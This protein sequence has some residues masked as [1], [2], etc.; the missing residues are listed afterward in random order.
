M[1]FNLFFFLVFSLLLS[2][3]AYNETNSNDRSSEKI[4]TERA[5]CK[6]TIL[7]NKSN[8]TELHLK[9]CESIITDTRSS[10]ML[11]WYKKTEKVSTEIAKYRL[12]VQEEIGKLGAQLAI[13]EKH[14][15]GFYIE[16]RPD[17]SVN[18]LLKGQPNTSKII[19]LYKD[20]SWLHFVKIRQAKYSLKDLKAIRQETDKIFYGFKTHFL[21]S[22]HV[23]KN[24]IVYVIEDKKAFLFKLKKKNI[25]LHE[26]VRIREGQS[27]V[28]TLI[29][30]DNRITVNLPEILKPD[31]YLFRIQFDEKTV[32]TYKVH[33]TNKLTKDCKRSKSS[34]PI[35][36]TKNSRSH[37]GI[38][39]NSAVCRDKKNY[40]AKSVAPFKSFTVYHEPN[41]IENT[42][43][44]VKF[45]IE[46]LN[47]QGKA[48]LKRN[49]IVQFDP[50]SKRQ[51]NGE[52]CEPICYKGSVNL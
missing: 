39:V 1:H 44:Q 20:K 15:A 33:I 2:A 43:D 51:P 32:N 12:G 9:H 48:V 14:D 37:R 10:G 19:Q 11:D 52:R 36:A 8:V 17:F 49:K 50:K 6:N 26:S 23:Q 35:R 7:K 16:H 34:P 31:N 13:D 24:Q 28:C 3:C 42:N 21:S 29:G 4:S 38:L 45:K 18:I 30:C 5:I 47:G 27:Y 40:S 46:V 41:S 22:G 25:K